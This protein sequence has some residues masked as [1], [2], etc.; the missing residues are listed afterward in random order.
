MPSYFLSRTPNS[1]GYGLNRNDNEMASITNE[2]IPA[3]Q[4]EIQVCWLL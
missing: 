4:T 2:D 1:A 3:V